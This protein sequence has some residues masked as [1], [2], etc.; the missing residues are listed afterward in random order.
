MSARGGNRCRCGRAAPA[1]GIA[2]L[3]AGV[4]WLLDRGV[5]DVRRHGR[6]L[7]GGLLEGL[8]GVPGVTVYGPRAEEERLPLVSFTVAGVSP[9]EVGCVLDEVYG[10]MVRTGL[11][12]APDAHRSLGT[13]DGGG[14][15]RA[16]F[17]PFNT[18]TDVDAA[19]EATAE[20][21]RRAGGSGVVKR[22]GASR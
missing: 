7:T 13:L 10:I 20:I 9:V 16:S 19:L 11:H 8:L 18:R 5:A 3:G 2:G 17:G 6:Q 4:R 14:L 12:C 22:A 1:A 21:A 15:V